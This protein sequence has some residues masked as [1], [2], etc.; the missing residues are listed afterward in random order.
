MADILYGRN[1]VLEAMRA[2]RT[3]Y[4]VVCAQ[5][6]EH[7]KRIGEILSLL[8]PGVELEA[9]SRSN[10]DDMAHS[11]H[12]QGIVAYFRKRALLSLEQLLGA[13]A[14]PAAILALDGI[15][16]PQNFGSLAR[17]ADAAGFGG[18]IITK[19]RSVGVTPA[20]VKTSAGAVEHLAVCE[21]TNLANSLEMMKKAG[22]WVVGLA[23]EGSLRYDQAD[24][25]GPLVLVV[26]SEGSGLRPLTRKRCDFLVRIPMEGAVSSLNAGVAGALLM[27]EVARQRGF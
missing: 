26:G 9:R 8:P 12:H 4:R 1:A 11:E 20:V 5:G 22:L 15:Q 10:L 17:S 2:G 24:L 16:D 14:A 13:V 23:A 25:T 6:L 7:D 27:Y 19:E 21:V 18:I 3:P